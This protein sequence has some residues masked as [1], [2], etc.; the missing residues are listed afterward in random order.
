LDDDQACQ[1]LS[2]QGPNEF[3]E[4]AAKKHVSHAVRTVYRDQG[5]DSIDRLPGLGLSVQAHRDDRNHGD[6]AYLPFLDEF[7]EVVPLSATDFGPAVALAV[8]V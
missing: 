8:V 6:A 1:L 7:F 3:I 2:E 5:C 4:R